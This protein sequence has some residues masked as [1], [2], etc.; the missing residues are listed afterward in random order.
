VRTDTKDLVSV[1]D[2]GRDFSRL[3]GEVAEGRTFVVLKNSKP[4]AAIVP[5]KTMDRLSRIDELEEDLKMFGIA[6]VRALT[7]SG[8]RY[9][10]DEVAREFGIDL[11]SED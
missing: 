7:D 4:T 6:V 10:L 2:A 5:M 8:Q 9:D 1:T 3:A 11:D